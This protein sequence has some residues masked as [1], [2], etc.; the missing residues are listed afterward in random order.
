LILSY[1]ASGTRKKRVAQPRGSALILL[2]KLSSVGRRKAPN[3]DPEIDKRT[4]PYEHM[5][6]PTERHGELTRGQQAPSSSNKTYGQNSRR[7]LTRYI[8]VRVFLVQR[9]FIDSVKHPIQGRTITHNGESV[10]STFSRAREHLDRIRTIDTEDY[11]DVEV[12]LFQYTIV[13]LSI[14]KSELP[15]PDFGAFHY[16]RFNN[17]GD[18]MAEFSLEDGII[19]EEPDITYKR[20]YQKGEIVYILGMNV[21]LG[22]PS[23]SG[24]YAVI[25][26][27][28]LEGLSPEGYYLA[29]FINDFGVLDHYHIPEKF[30]A[31]LDRK[32]PPEQEFLVIA[33]A[34]YKGSLDLPTDLVGRIWDGEVFVAKKE[35]FDWRP[36]VDKE[37]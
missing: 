28:P 29:Y 18:L 6:I 11:D 24:N 33:S 34:L 20:L 27:T 7:Y 31:K 26:N 9:L 10:F 25:G 15:G 36:F 30:I 4:I 5:D 19:E 22:S 17:N 2:G 8:I 37:L 35:V 13:E 14:D 23:V 32:L 16:W 3:D 12:A 1:I 21:A